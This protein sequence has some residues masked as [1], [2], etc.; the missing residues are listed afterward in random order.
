MKTLTR[1]IIVIAVA[2]MSIA[3]CSSD[4]EQTSEE[5]TSTASEEADP[6]AP[7]LDDRALSVGEAREGQDVV[8]TLREVEYPYPPAESRQPDEGNEFVGLHLEQCVR[9][10]VAEPGITTYNAEWSAVTAEGQ[11]YAGNG[12]YWSDWPSPKFPESVGSV[13]GRC[14]EGWLV[15]QVPESTQ[16]ER[17][18]WRP[19][20]TPTAEWILP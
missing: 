18:M 11:E 2:A 16:I 1:T 6:F 14:V 15:L 5:P 19:E 8:T 13:A 9:E 4:D 7:N 10:G 3:G 20:A 12:S 17:L